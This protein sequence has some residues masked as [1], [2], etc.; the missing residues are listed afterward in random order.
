MSCVVQASPLTA[1]DF[2]ST[3]NDECSIQLPND[4][5]FGN[6]SSG[7]F[8][9]SLLNARAVKYAAQH[10][11]I[12]QQADVRS[13][14]VSFFRPIFPAKG[15]VILKVEELSIGKA[16]STL[17][18]GAFQESPKLCATA[19]IVV[20][21]LSIPGVT[22][23]TH[24][25]PSFSAPPVSLAALE[26]HSDPSWTCYHTAFHPQ[27]FRRGHSYI[28]NYVPLSWPEPI[29]CIEQWVAPGW[30]CLP[31]G[32]RDTSLPEARWTN[33]L[34]PFVA[35]LHLP[36]QE[37]FL[38]HTPGTKLPLGSVAAT[39]GFAAAQKKA[40]DQGEE[41]WRDVDGDGAIVFDAKLIHVS[42]T[43]GCEVKK[44]L[45]GTGVRFLFVRAEVKKVVAG[46]MDLEVLIFDEQLE[47]V[48]V[49][50]QVAH[51][52]AAESKNERKVGK[53]SL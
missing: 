22:L 51:L 18:V 24:W 31:R 5:G 17:R 41:K 50:W 30:D 34:L 1:L 45:P 10:P 16:W 42:L 40:R 32:S 43:M 21:S 35:D 20:A 36:V 39:L 33:S 4:I 13:S 48:M 3:G 25:S 49:G 9:A 26:T 19:D 15:L 6:V 29:T 47:L 46:R 23:N 52:I 12:H 7:G 38:P 14:T 44:K 37:N 27:G 8:V 53:T 11:K 2:R 28:K